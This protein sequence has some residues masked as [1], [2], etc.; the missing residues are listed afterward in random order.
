LGT[1]TTGSLAKHWLLW[2]HSW[3]VSFAL[4]GLENCR[5]PRGLYCGEFLQFNNGTELNNVNEWTPTGP[6]PLPH[7]EFMGRMLG[8]AV[9]DQMLVELPLASFFISKL[10]GQR[11]VTHLHSQQCVTLHAFLRQLFWSILCVPADSNILSPDADGDHVD[12]F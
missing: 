1:T 5:W 2:R 4:A 11:P 10:V 8:K 6:N 3:F 12:H 7:F 9:Y